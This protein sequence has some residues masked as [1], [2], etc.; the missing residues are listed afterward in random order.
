MISDLFLFH[1]WLKFKK[2]STY[3]YILKKRQ[4]NEERPKKTKF[5][6]KKNQGVIVKITQPIDEEI[7]H[8]I[9]KNDKKYSLGLELT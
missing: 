6:K 8:Y 2:L 1:I 9:K 5:K 4:K 7:K 3:E